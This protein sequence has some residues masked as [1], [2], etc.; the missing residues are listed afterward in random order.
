MQTGA[1][2]A[3]T[4]WGK[5]PGAQSSGSSSSW[6]A[7]EPPPEAVQLFSSLFQGSSQHFPQLREVKGGKGRLEITL[8]PP[9]CLCA[10]AGEEKQATCEGGARGASV[11]TEGR[12]Y[13]LAW[14]QPAGLYSSISPPY[15]KCSG[16]YFR[17]T[18]T[19]LSEATSR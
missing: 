7:S 9:A 3:K 4:Q 13:F 16:Q 19:D 10:A 14:C 12:I 11:P 2:A 6:A 5:Q 18:L 17:H 8:P 15:L 1:K